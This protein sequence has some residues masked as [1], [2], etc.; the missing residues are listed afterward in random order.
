[1]KRIAL[2]A[3]SLVALA[4]CGGGETPAP[5]APTET[6]AAETSTPAPAP[7]A[8]TLTSQ[9]WGPLKIGMTRDEVIAA[10]GP[11]A[12]PDAVGGPDPEACDEFRPANAPQG[13]LVMIESGKLTR[14]SLIELSPLKTDKG[15]GIGDTSAVVKTTYGSAAQ[16]SPH[17]YQDPPAEYITV[18]DGGPRT[19]PYV[20]DETARGLVYEIDGTGKVG[21]VRAGGPSIQLVEGCA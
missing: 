12:N 2:V 11:D 7:A 13:I 10:L 4:A 5:A 1:M 20:Q 19:E 15:L 18:W 16:V 17:K 9:G 21:A 6:P 8:E 14:V 3:A